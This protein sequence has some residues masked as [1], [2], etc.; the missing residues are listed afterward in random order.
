MDQSW[1]RE[2]HLP[3]G[4]SMP[5]ALDVARRIVEVNSRHVAALAKNRRWHLATDRLEEEQ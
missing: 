5:P 4:L 2:M 1:K 3:L